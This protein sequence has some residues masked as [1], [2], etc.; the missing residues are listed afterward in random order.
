MN[1]E[2]LKNL[3]VTE[4][5]KKVIYWSN[6]ISNYNEP[7]M[8]VLAGHPYATTGRVLYDYDIGLSILKHDNSDICLTN[9]PGAMRNTATARYTNIKEYEINLNN[10]FKLLEKGSFDGQEWTKLCKHSVA[11]IGIVHPICTFV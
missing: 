1:T 5:E 6:G 8:G 10:A 3:D 9:I 4:L 7:E 11:R 2:E